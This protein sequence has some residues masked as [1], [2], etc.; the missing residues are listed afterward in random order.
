VKNVMARA[1]GEA[2][3]AKRRQRGTPPCG[4]ALPGR[5]G[6]IIEDARITDNRLP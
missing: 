5:G 3:V 6:D 1:R 2:A 4:L